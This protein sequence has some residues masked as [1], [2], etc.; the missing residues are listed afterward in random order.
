M[1]EILRNRPRCGLFRP[2]PEWVA[3]KLDTRQNLR[4]PQQLLELFQ[5]VLNIDFRGVISRNQIAGIKFSIRKTD[6]ARAWQRKVLVDDRKDCGTACTLGAI[7]WMLTPRNA[8]ASVNLVCRPMAGLA[9]G[10]NS[11]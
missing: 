10:A 7:G 8:R 11:R 3:R 2:G 4:A 1:G 5:Q 9:D 6:D